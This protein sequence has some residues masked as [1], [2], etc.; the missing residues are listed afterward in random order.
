VIRKL[1]R[2]IFRGDFSRGTAR[3]IVLDRVRLPMLGTADGTV[4]PFDLLD[5]CAR[6][7]AV[8]RRTAGQ[9]GDALEFGPL[10]LPIESRFVS[11]HGR[12][13]DVTR[14]EF[15]LLEALVRNRR[16]VLTQH[17]LEDALYGWGHEVESNA[18]AVHVRDVRRKLSGK[19]IRTVRGLGYTLTEDLDS[20]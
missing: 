10:T 5:L 18:I 3:D 11:W 12:K 1:S 16:R 17:Q 20:V 4:K 14:K 9:S 19:L 15:R 7:R 6:L 2:R 8:V 13:V